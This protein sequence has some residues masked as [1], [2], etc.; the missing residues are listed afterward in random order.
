MLHRLTHGL[1]ELAAGRR[2]EGRLLIK[3]RR[4]ADHFLPGGAAG[5]AG[6][7]EAL[8]ELAARHADR[9]EEVFLA[10]AARVDARGDK[11]A[12]SARPAFCGSTSTIPASCTR[13]GRSSPSAP[14]TC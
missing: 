10:P 11:H 4:R 5:E 3:T 8:L 13:C 14:A 1:V 9:G 6:W 12:V 7:L 2:R